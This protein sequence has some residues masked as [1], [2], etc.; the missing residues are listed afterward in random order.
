MEATVLPGVHVK[1][2]M[3][4]WFTNQYS[5]A[6]KMWLIFFYE[7]EASTTLVCVRERGM[8]IFNAK[9]GEGIMP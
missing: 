6:E 9:L 5:K 2:W 3:V 8:R 7:T 1:F 4:G